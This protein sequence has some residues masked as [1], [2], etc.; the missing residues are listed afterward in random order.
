MTKI[1]QKKKKENNLGY[2]FDTKRLI[3]CYRELKYTE[4]GARKFAP[5]FDEAVR[6]ESGDN[7][8]EL[9][10]YFISYALEIYPSVPK[11]YPCSNKVGIFASL[12]RILKEKGLLEEAVAEVACLIIHKRK[13]EKI[14]SDYEAH[15]R[16]YLNHL[17][18]H[19]EYKFTIRNSFKDIEDVV[20]PYYN[21]L[22]YVL[23][24]KGNLKVTEKEEID[25]LVEVLKKYDEKFII[26]AVVLED[27]FN[28]EEGSK[29]SNE[30][31]IV[32]SLK[33]GALDTSSLSYYNEDG[34][35]V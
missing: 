12:F 26:R 15:L 29:L 4:L 2:N 32:M 8:E 7:I 25:K 19:H 1:K 6:E 3:S 22:L 14:I 5:N 20:K 18:I 34:N 21:K 10:N 9:K 35:L 16:Y 28:S 27:F 30:D 24:N 23:K 13:D 11:D 31:K 33:V 17:E